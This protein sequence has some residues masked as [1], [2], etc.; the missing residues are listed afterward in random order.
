MYKYPICSVKTSYRK[1]RQMQKTGKINKMSQN[2]L[3]KKITMIQI[4]EKWTFV[5]S[6][7]YKGT[8]KVFNFLLALSLI[9]I[10]REHTWNYWCKIG[11]FTLISSKWWY[12]YAFVPVNCSAKKHVSFFFSITDLLNYIV[13]LL[14]ICYYQCTYFPLNLIECMRMLI[15]HNIKV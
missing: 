5:K 2:S 7:F 12:I 1:R 4:I 6:Y 8:R 3:Q 14:I 11:C 15:T 10:S 9:N 13:I